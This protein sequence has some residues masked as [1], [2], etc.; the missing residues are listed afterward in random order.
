MTNPKLCKDCKWCENTNIS[1]RRCYH[2]DLVKLDLV[3][4][5]IDAPFS[6]MERDSFWISSKCKEEG[7]LW[8]QKEELPYEQRPWWKVL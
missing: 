2:P 5:G 3:T 7:L 4:G 8:E 6:N 1:K